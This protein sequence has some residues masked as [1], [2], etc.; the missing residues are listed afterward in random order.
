MSSVR[1]EYAPLRAALAAGARI[2][3][4]V[5]NHEGERS[6]A[7]GSWSIVV[8]PKFTCPAHL[9]RIYPADQLWAAKVILEQQIAKLDEMHPEDAHLVQ[10]D[11]IGSPLYLA[12]G[13]E[14]H[15][16]AD[17]HAAAENLIDVA[18]FDRDEWTVTD[19]R[20]PTGD[21]AMESAQ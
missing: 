17:S 15:F 2:Q 20:N 6:C 1:D 9:Y 5:L 12:S 8:G 18:S 21:A 14:G 13:P 10:N 19:L 16:F 3:R 11:G 4:W 7:N